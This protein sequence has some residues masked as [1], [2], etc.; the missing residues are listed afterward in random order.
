MKER[1]ACVQWFVYGFAAAGALCSVLFWI[2]A[3]KVG[4]I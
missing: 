1:E 3:R 2:V 4:M